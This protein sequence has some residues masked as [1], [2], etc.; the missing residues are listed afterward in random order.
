MAVVTLQDII[1]DYYDFQGDDPPAT[2]LAQ[3]LRLINR[4]LEEMSRRQ[5]F[6][7]S[8][9]TV[10]TTMTS[11]IGSL[12]T[13]FSNIYDVRVIKS[14]TR[15]DVIF[16]RIDE[17]SKDSFSSGTPS[18]WITGDPKGGYKLNINTTDATVSTTYYRRSSILAAL[19]DETFYPYS[20]PIA[21]GAYLRKR[22]IDNPDADVTQEKLEYEQSITMLISYDQRVN[23]RKGRYIGLHEAS[24]MRTGNTS[25]AGAAG[26]VGNNN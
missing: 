25:F 13:D 26:T 2:P 3:D 8:R 6:G 17:A 15:D 20:E 4:T 12:L 23:G 9:A 24:N 22:K 5:N 19:S 10:D 14:G 16:R 11:K 21:L 18:Y 7:F 1:N